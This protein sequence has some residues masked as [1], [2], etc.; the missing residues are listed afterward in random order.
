MS[1]DI[2]STNVNV[3]HQFGRRVTEFEQVE[4][5]FLK[6]V[7]KWES[8]TDSCKIVNYIETS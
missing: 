6:G 8:C 7:N 1:I 5:P 2:V 4:Q 3:L